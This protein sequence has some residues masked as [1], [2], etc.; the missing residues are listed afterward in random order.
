M[1]LQF[2]PANAL[3]GRG[4]G[5]GGAG[6]FLAPGAGPLLAAL[7]GCTVFSGEPVLMAAVRD[8]SASLAGVFP[9]ANESAIAA[10]AACI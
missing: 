3:V 9:I 1:N 2:L 10:L 8:G 6:G 4:G 5:G 7:G